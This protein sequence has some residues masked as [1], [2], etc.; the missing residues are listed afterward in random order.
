V[1]V[2]VKTSVLIANDFPLVR[3][4]MRELLNSTPHMYVVACAAAKSEVLPLVESYRPQ[5]GILDLEEEWAELTDLVKNLCTR[6]IPTLV[7]TDA[8]DD[9]QTVDLLKAGANGII[10]RRVDP[11]ML[12]RSVH[13]VACGEI[14]V[15]RIATNQL[16]QRLRMQ[17]A[18]VK[19]IPREERPLVCEPAP[20]VA[21]RNQFGLTPREMD[22]VRAIG[23]AMSN[24]DIA[25]HF[26]ISEYTV[27]HH[28]TKIF[29][30]IG[31]YS[32]L[33]LAMM[34]THHGLVTNQAQAIA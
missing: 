3:N 30:K 4:S 29:D 22:I 28:L 5:V 12:C 13:A 33:E 16:I 17:P 18:A 10:S 27:K 2:D 24:R 20:Q 19:A 1:G 34:A 25:A 9:E 7:M 6:Q 8:L 32:R 14:W 21:V 31:V 15:S 11:E 26:G 23:E